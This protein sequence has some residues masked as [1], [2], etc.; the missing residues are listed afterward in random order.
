MTFL[1]V[2]LVLAAADADDSLAKK[3]LPI[4]IKDAS[5][6]SMAVES[7]AKME[8]ELKKE[9]VFEWT[10][11]VRGGHGVVFLWL[12]E[13]RP[14][15]L[16]SIWSEPDRKLS[17]RRVFHEFHAL[18]REKLLVSRPHT[19]NEWK[20][21]AGLERKELS[22]TAAPEATRGARLVQMRRLAQ[23]FT[24]YE[25]EGPGDR[26]D[27]RL[28]STPL[29]RYPACKRGV[30]DGAL[31]ALVSTE[32]TDPEVLL[33]LEARAEDGKTCWQYACGRFGSRNLHVQRKDKEVWSSLLDGRSSTW[34]H[35][36]LHLYRTYP[37]K[38]VSLDGRLLARVRSTEKNWWGEAIPVN[39]K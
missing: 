39:E 34:S 17:G 24:G 5:E 30:I 8:L 12:R 28:L 27:L 33:I 35:D 18:D 9:S 20:P 22:D 14:T 2:L 23:E 16:G 25:D 38:V 21:Q 11:P 36:Q 15:A 37:D 1:S 26:L 4:Y 31:F 13:G 6:Y 10:N 3:M 19:L 7:A 29:Y 32:G